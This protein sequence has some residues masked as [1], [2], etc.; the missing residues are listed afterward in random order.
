MRKAGAQNQCWGPFLSS[1][2]I[3]FAPTRFSLSLSQ[4]T[5]TLLVSVARVSQKVDFSGSQTGAPLQPFVAPLL[6]E[7]TA[8][9][10]ACSSGSGVGGAPSSCQEKSAAQAQSPA[11]PSPAATATVSLA[12]RGLADM[13]TRPPAALV[14]QGDVD[15]VVGEL[16]AVLG[17]PRTWRGG[18][19]GGEGEDGASAG[20]VC[21]NEG[22][23]ASAVL[24]A[25]R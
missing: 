9:L 23:A 18:V 13:I 22:T 21:V 14:G 15:G 1:P 7:F 17:E 4:P 10:D 6:A 2:M 19:G 20:G 12:A 3:P 5:L 16:A 8:A 25:L 11:A 24:S